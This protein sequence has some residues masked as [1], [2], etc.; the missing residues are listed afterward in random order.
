MTGNGPGKYDDLLTV[1][2]EGAQAEGAILMIFSGSKG[3]GFE[4]Q[5]PPHIIVQ[6]PEI[7][8]DMADK[9]DELRKA[10]TTHHTGP[11]S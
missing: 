5:V 10:K 7:L 4:V 2:R 6:I 9:L 1:A 3:S 11:K 8:R